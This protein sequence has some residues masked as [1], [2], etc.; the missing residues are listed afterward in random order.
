MEEQKDGKYLIK[1]TIPRLSVFSAIPRI[2]ISAQ[3]DFPIGTIMKRDGSVKDVMIELEIAFDGNK[4]NNLEE[5]NCSPIAHQTPGLSP[6]SP[7]GGNG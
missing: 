5:I 1:K 4:E 7:Q 6:G 3:R 2:L